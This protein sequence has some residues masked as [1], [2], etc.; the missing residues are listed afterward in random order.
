MDY[1]SLENYKFVENNGNLEIAIK[2][3]ENKVICGIQPWVSMLHTYQG[4]VPMVPFP[5]T[6]Y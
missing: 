2:G 5:E 4:S 1:L 3:P 6:E